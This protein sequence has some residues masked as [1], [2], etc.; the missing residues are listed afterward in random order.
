MKKLLGILVLGLLWC[1]VG[2]A[3]D[4]C[5]EGNCQNGQGTFTW[6]DGRKYIGEYKDDKRHGQG[7]LIFSNGDK[8]VGEWKKGK[9]NGFGTMFFSDGE[10]YVG[11][12]KDN[13]RHGQGTVTGWISFYD[14]DL[15]LGYSGQYKNGCWDGRGTLTYEYKDSSKKLNRTY[16][17][18]FSDCKI[19]GQG[20]WVWEDGLRTEGQ[21]KDGLQHGFGST[22]Y[23]D[24]GKYIG[25]FKDDRYHGQG[26]L[27]FP[28]TDKAWGW[29]ENEKLQEKY[30][31]AIYVGEFKNGEFDGKGTFTLKDGSK[32]IGVW[33][34]GKLISQK[35]ETHASIKSNEKYYALLIGNDNYKFWEKLDAP[36]NDVTEIG[37]ILKSKYRFDVQVVK[38]A[39]ANTIREKLIELTKKIKTD[40]NLL[41]Y[42]SGHGD[43][44]INMSPP[45][46]YWIPVD[47]GKT[48]DSK[49]INT[50]DISAYISQIPAKHILLM[51]DSCYS[52]SSI[53]GKN[54][55]K[56]ASEKNLNNQKWIKKMLNRKTRQ[57]ITSGGIAPVPDS[58]VDNHSLFA[59]KFIDILKTNENYTTGSKVWQE[60]QYHIFSVSSQDPKILQLKEMG[61]LDGDFFFIA[62]K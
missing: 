60:L 4:V 8:Y 12:W 30:I 32:Q 29:E 16:Y 59:Y 57:V 46:A 22:V 25:E 5:I 42:Y 62:K 24:G 6:A 23:P 41:I 2:F 49:W 11:E 37:K 26:K 39:S 20:I 56:V 55:V 1:N 58:V 61:D 53:K 27:T 35:T 17:G 21:Y 36:V 38:N 40:D 54:K 43:R 3:Q 50:Q 31:G 9:R 18:E 51:I 34:A 7:T 14:K 47:G 15:I 13:Q 44:N 28:D 33:K 45:R 52:G 10:K 19:N 48:F